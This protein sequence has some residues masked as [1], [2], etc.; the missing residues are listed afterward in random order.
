MVR[1]SKILTSTVIMSMLL[2]I[3][4]EK[5]NL[6]YEKLE[7]DSKKQSIANEQKFAFLLISTDKDSLCS[8]IPTSFLWGNN[9]SKILWSF[10]SILPLNAK[11]HRF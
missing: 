1:S 3:L 8:G 4:K 6:I 11:S 9:L 7:T 2:D 5:G 10:S